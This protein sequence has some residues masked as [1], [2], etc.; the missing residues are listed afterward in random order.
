MEAIIKCLGLKMLQVTSYELRVI[1][2]KNS[3]QSSVISDQIKDQGSRK[4]VQGARMNDIE[5]QSEN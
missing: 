1:E 4:K 2:L 5:M 3:N